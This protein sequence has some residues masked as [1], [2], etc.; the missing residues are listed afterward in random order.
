MSQHYVSMS[1][2]VL[3][4][5]LSALDILLASVGT[6]CPPIPRAHWREKRL[7]VGRPRI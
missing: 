7:T 3:G 4:I 1:D 5:S 2:K 6:F